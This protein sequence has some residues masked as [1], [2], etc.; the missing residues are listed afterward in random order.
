MKAPCVSG[1]EKLWDNIYA[2]VVQPEVSVSVKDDRA[3][4]ARHPNE[5]VVWQGHGT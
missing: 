4:L 2:L 5:A 1:E 3:T